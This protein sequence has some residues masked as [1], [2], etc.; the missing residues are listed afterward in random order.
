MTAGTKGNLLSQAESVLKEAKK[1]LDRDNSAQAGTTDARDTP[2]AQSAYNAAL[3]KRNT[4]QSNLD[5]EMRA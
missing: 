1:R 5:R 2:D 3:E 4:A